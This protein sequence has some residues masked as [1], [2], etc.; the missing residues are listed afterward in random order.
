MGHLILGGE[1]TVIDTESRLMWKRSDSMNDMEKWVNYQDS[2]DYTRNLSENKFAGFDNW[3]LPTRD[4]MDRLYDKS[5]S[6]KDK[7]EKDIH[8]CDCFSPGG[9]FS[10]IAQQ[11]SGRMRTFILNLRTGEYDQPDGLW[12]LTEAARAVRSMS[13][14]ESISSG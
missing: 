6:I 10:M 13:P 14:D 1:H 9:G 8:I 5:Y 12:T 2:L 4:E 3:R 11:I 7:F